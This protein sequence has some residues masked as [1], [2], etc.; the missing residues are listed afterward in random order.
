MGTAPTTCPSPHA[1]AEMCDVPRL[2][3][4]VTAADVVFFDRPGCPYCSQAKAAL[5][6]A[7]VA[8]TIESHDAF[9]SELIATTGKSSAPS[10]WIKGNYIGGC[11][12]GTEPWHGVRPM[13]RNGKF[14]QMLSGAA[15]PVVPV[16]VATDSSS[17]SGW[18]C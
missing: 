1:H 3:A 5:D 9:R 16:N 15:A 11:N 4:A 14:E 12:D 18:W 6:K 7:G 10:V 2:Q 13:L 17:R 8:Y